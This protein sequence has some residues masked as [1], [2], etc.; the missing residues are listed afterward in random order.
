MPS[1]EDMANIYSEITHLLKV[2]HVNIIEVYHQDKILVECAEYPFYWRYTVSSGRKNKL[3]LRAG[4]RPGSCI[5]P[6]MSWVLFQLV[7][8]EHQYVA[9]TIRKQRPQRKKGSTRHTLHSSITDFLGSAGAETPYG[10]DAEY[11]GKADEG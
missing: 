6:V 11:D 1:P 3:R 5:L 2:I 9:E 7:Q 8:T 4:Q 10:Y